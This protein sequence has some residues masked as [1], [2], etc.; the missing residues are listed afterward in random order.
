MLAGEAVRSGVES[1]LISS[2]S[3]GRVPVNA[4]ARAPAAGG[5]PSMP[6][7]TVGSPEWV[8]SMVGGWAAAGTRT[9]RSPPGLDR[10]LLGKSALGQ[11]G[12]ESRVGEPLLERDGVTRWCWCQPDP[13]HRPGSLQRAVSERKTA[14]QYSEEVGSGQER[15]KPGAGQAWSEE[16]AG[17]PLGRDWGGAL[18][19]SR[20]ARAEACRAERGLGACLTPL[21]LLHHLGH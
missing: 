13:G 15:K 12:W 7:V 18:G 3:L 10:G 5:L 6:G 20:A 17:G 9:G 16:R 19:L 4:S 11:M 14:E 2:S 21:L 8:A 1:A